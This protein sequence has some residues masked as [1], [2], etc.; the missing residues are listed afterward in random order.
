MSGGSH[1]RRRARE[2]GRE[3]ARAVPL[4][5]A[6]AALR[7][8]IF[9]RLEDRPPLRVR[10]ACHGAV[11]PGSETAAPSET[12]ASAC[13]SLDRFL[14]RHDLIP[15]MGPVPC[16]GRRLLAQAAR[17][18]LPVTVTSESASTAGP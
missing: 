13:G 9:R 6:A 8:L 12:A 1:V 18:T 2:R 11:Q 7:L 15:P 16:T 17:R 14:C 5:R 4:Q 3:P 10:V